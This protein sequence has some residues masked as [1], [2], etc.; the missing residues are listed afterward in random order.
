MKAAPQKSW[1]ASSKTFKREWFVV[2]A[3]NRTLGRMATKVAMVLMGKHKPTWTPFLDTGDFVVIVNAEKAK[4]TGRKREGR[5]YN[6]FSG[7]PGGRKEFSFNDW[8][9]RH[10]EDVV[11]HAIKDM[12]PNSPLGRRQR[13]KLF[14]YK[15]EKHPHE[16]Q[17]PKPLEIK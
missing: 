2:D 7:Y 9:E 17:Q 13:S 12:I 15:G 10:P 8:F 16:A 6:T 5:I 14:V 3:T 1:V 11:R 4:V